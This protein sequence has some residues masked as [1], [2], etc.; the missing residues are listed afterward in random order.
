[1]GNP[2][3]GNLSTMNRLL[4]AT[5]FAFVALAASRDRYGTVNVRPGLLGGSYP[6][7]NGGGIRQPT[8]GGGIN[9]YT[10]NN[11]GR[12]HGNCRYWCK[13]PQ[14]RAYCCETGNDA[15]A[16]VGVKPGKCPVPRPVCPVHTRFGPPK[17]CSNDGTCHGAEKCCF[18]TCLKEHV[19]KPP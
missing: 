9:N 5:L 8:H 10:P 13:D 3:G 11:G 14:G 1:M 19:C 15:P 18:D 4:I 6:G 2:G 12:G 16:P 17:T 7:H